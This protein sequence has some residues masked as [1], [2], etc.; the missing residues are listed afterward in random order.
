MVFIG[1]PF[2]RSTFTV[3]ESSREETPRATGAGHVQVQQQ[4]QQQQHYS[5]RNV[6][7]I[8]VNTVGIQQQ[9]H[10]SHSAAS[11]IVQNA[12]VL[13]GGTAALVT[14]NN[15]TPQQPDLNA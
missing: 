15:S 9:Q 13:G 3:M 6:N 5:I 11:V 14:M 2:Q 1:E 4:Q 7:P 12:A 8:V 10:Y